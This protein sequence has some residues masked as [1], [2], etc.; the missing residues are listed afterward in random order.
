MR[1]I[2]SERN[3]YASRD[4]SLNKPV[5]I[6]TMAAVG[7]SKLRLLTTEDTIAFRTFVEVSK[8]KVEISRNFSLKNL[9]QSTN[10]I[11]SQKNDDDKYSESEK[12]D[13][14][15][16]MEDQNLGEDLSK[17]MQLVK[18]EN[19]EDNHQNEKYDL[20]P[21]S[22]EVSQASEHLVRN[23]DDLF[24]IFDSFQSAFY[25]GETQ[26]AMKDDKGAVDDDKAIY[27][28]SILITILGEN[29][30]DFIDP[31]TGEWA[32]E[33]SILEHFGKL[34]NEEIESLLKGKHQS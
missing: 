11:M 28:E 34:F 13:K 4:K 3:Y 2:L 24:N 23:L 16:D 14:V 22:S 10:Q 18:Y 33:K 25:S 21:Q 6:S 9:K 26:I 31:T 32:N 27:E 8:V 30:M 5:I 15:P 1:P 20:L 12:D 7:L 17:Q 29:Y 19:N